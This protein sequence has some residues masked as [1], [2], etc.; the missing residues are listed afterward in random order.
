MACFNLTRRT[1]KTRR[2]LIRR[3]CGHAVV[4][5]LCAGALAGCGAS[6]QGHKIPVALQPQRPPGEVRQP[7]VALVVNVAAEK[8]GALANDPTPQELSMRYELLRTFEKS[9]CFSRVSSGGTEELNVD[10]RVTVVRKSSTAL[11][12]LSIVSLSLIPSYYTDEYRVMATVTPLN[13]TSHTYTLTDTVTTVW[14]LLILPVSPFADIV[15]VA[16]KV[17]RNL[18]TTLIVRMQQDGL[19]AGLR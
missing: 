12:V 3:T 7:S 17:Q 2:L 16:D 15:F 11:Q 10:I 8:F 18:W 6:F 14:G 4:V 5:V 19:L 9:G 1:A 13:G